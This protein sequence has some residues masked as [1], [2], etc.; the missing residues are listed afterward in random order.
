M[1]AGLCRTS[2]SSRVH[3]M[4]IVQTPMEMSAPTK[5]A[6]IDVV[7]ARDRVDRQII[8]VTQT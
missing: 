2:S 7:A 6:P 5:M 8:R 1:P 3:P 4:M